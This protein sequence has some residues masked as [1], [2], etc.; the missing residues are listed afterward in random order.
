MTATPQNQKTQNQ[1]SR[2]QDL[3]GYWPWFAGALFGAGVIHIAAV[4]AMPQLAKRDA[5]ARLAEISDENQMY[6]LPVA[7]ANL[8]A[9]PLPLMSPDLGYAFC[10]FNLKQNNVSVMAEFSEPSWTVSVSTRRG[11]NFYLI[12]GADARRKE[13]RLLITPRDRLAE[14]AS[15]EE[16]EEGEE[17]II[18]ISPSE[19]GVVMVRAPI[20]GPSYRRR[21][22]DALGK[23]TC[24]ATPTPEAELL[25]AA[26]EQEAARPASRASAS[27]AGGNA[28]RPRAGPARR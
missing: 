20:R 14:E 5:W 11:E 2:S 3:I 10:R 15:T 18:V 16:D 1:K 22:F 17:Q 8:P 19:E 21:T 6:V 26:R 27:A 28:P 9:P 7:D 4:L 23:I 25:A 13:L 24:E 12:S